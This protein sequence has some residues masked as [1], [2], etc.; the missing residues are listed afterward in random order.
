MNEPGD[1]RLKPGVDRARKLQIENH[2][3]RL[4]Y[5]KRM[6][7]DQAVIDGIQSTIDGL[8]DEL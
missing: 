3:E 4:A 5:A 2:Q 1:D 7:F 6:D 8:Q